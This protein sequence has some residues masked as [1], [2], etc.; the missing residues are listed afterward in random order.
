MRRGDVVLVSLDP[1]LPG[2]A[3]K[4]RPCVLVSNDGANGVPERLGRGVVTVVP[5]TSN[6]SRVYPNFEVGV[7][8]PD[9]LSS[10]G[11]KVPSKVQASQLRAVSVARLSGAIGHCPA[12]V[13]VELDAA[14]R[15]HLSL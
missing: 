1:A 5:I 7:L 10:M 9:A 13:L 2:E 3:A 8:E 15:F 6:V 4:L 14:I 12:V 11:L